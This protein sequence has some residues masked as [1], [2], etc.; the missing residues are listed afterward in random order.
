MDAN[1]TF[2][3]MFSAMKAHDYETARGLALDLQEWFANGGCHPHQHT[4]EAIDDYIASVLRRTAGF[5]PEPPFSLV[6]ERCDAGDDIE[7][8][9]QAFEQGWTA[10]GPAFDLPQ[11]N[12]CGICRACRDA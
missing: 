7:T 6:C 1:Q 12:Y 10:I 5:G 3:D 8:E 11:A 4:P 9:E 2:Q